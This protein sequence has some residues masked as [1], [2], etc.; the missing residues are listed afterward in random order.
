VGPLRGEY[1]WNGPIFIFFL[2]IWI[3]LD[4][5][6]SSRDKFITFFYELNHRIISDLNHSEKFA[7]GKAGIERLVFQADVQS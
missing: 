1:P 7:I 5:G 4:L 3:R 6:K 2:F